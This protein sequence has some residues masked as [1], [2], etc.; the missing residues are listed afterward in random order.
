M[1]NIT[2]GTNTMST[3]AKTSAKR[4]AKKEEVA[5]PAAAAPV[6]VAVAAAP[7]KKEK[8]ATP[9]AA[10]PVV[11]AVA[12]APVASAVSAPAEVAVPA[13]TVGQDIESVMSAFQ[14][15][16]DN[17]SKQIKALQALQKRVA[18]ELKDAG[19]RRRHRRSVEG[20]EQK[21][22]R[23]TIFTTPVTLKDE[24]AHF[25]GK[26]KGTQMTPAEVSKAVK[27]YIDSHKLKNEEKGQGHTI[28]PDVAMRK[29]LGIKEGESVTY[30]NIQSYLY[31]LYV[32]P[33]KK[34]KA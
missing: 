26:S 29:A 2:T 24:L 1:S 15:I 20:G 17:A 33:E 8:K 28:Y 12:A 3:A 14:A 30:R 16:R 9:A 10:A 27:V 5:A 11:A 22:K 7:A 23:P 6:A 34:V 4:V 18:R 19:R 25:L 31:K 13:T 32:L 21:E